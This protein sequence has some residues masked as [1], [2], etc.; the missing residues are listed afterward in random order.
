[1]KEPSGEEGACDLLGLA[2]GAVGQLLQP[3]EVEL[4]VEVLGVNFPPQFW[5]DTFLRE[6]KTQFKSRNTNSLFKKCLNLSLR[7][8]VDQFKTQC[9]CL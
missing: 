3:A 7:Y 4:V 5:R 6:N 2:V 1:M 8:L 9:L